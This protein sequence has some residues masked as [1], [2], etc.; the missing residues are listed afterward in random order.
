VVAGGEKEVKGDGGERGEG[1]K[2]IDEVIQREKNSKRGRGKE[3]RRK[4]ERSPLHPPHHIS[5]HLVTSHLAISPSRHLAISPSRLPSAAHSNRH[6]FAL[7]LAKYMLIRRIMNRYPGSPT[8]SRHASSCAIASF[9]TIPP[10]VM[11]RGAKGTVRRGQYSFFFSLA[12]LVRMFWIEDR[13]RLRIGRGE[14]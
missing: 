13:A 6:T 11:Q 14:D 3:K 9:S 7:A 8:T 5:S 10:T 12:R 2:G 4:R 1:G